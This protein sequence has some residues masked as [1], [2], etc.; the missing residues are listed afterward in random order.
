MSMIKSLLARL[1]LL[2]RGWY[3]WL[4]KPSKTI[5]EIHWGASD[6]PK[7]K[8]LCLFSTYDSQG[9]I[10]PYVKEYLKQIS[11]CGFDIA[12]IA[13]S[14]ALALSDVKDISHFCRVVVLRQNIG[15]DFGSWKAATEILPDWTDYD[16]LLLV[17]DSVY[18]P[19]GGLSLVM[20]AMEEAEESFLGLTDSFEQGHHLQSYFLYFKKPLLQSKVFRDFWSS[21]KLYLD[22]YYIIKKYEVGMS[23]FFV[24]RDVRFKAFCSYEKV[25]DATIALGEN[26][27]F[28]DK[29]KVEP[30]NPSLY[31]WNILMSNFKF[32]FLKTE[33]L[34]INRYAFPEVRTW[35]QFIP[36]GSA[37]WRPLIESHL[38]RTCPTAAGLG[39]Q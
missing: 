3:W 32:P 5:T 16:R 15:I 30:L 11:I 26:F 9:R 22:K 36:E 31:M 28:H 8:K 10:D 12:V 33:I 20:A 27:K 4:K 35:W 34:K 6:R 2:L 39:Q 38:K 7:Q 19:F 13:T 1:H 25:K 23:H 29:V 18:G 21:I 37:E 24:Q 14:P 17:N